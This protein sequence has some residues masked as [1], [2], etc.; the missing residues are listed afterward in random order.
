MSS[1]G[2]WIFAVALNCFGSVLVNFSA[3]LI[4][5]AHNYE[6]DSQDDHL[7]KEKGE[8]IFDKGNTKHTE[9][10][11][12]RM[13]RL[14]S[15]YASTKNNTSKNIWKTG[16]T[17]FALGS[18]INFVSLGLAAQSMLAVLG[19]VQFIS[20]IFFAQWLLKEK[21]TIRRLWATLV[22]R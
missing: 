15:C 12:S 10:F 7:T 22:R 11:N 9:S 21:I 19:G 16:M 17:F 6:N 4:K 14:A 3:N 8:V 5:A 18:I 13:W 2:L 20:N 1:D